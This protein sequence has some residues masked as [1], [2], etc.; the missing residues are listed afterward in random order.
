MTLHMDEG[1]MPAD[2]I[3]GYLRT[4]REGRKFKQKDFGP[5]I[6]MSERAYIDW[7]LG[8]TGDMKS[9]FLLRAL[10]LLGATWEDVQQ[11]AG[12]TYEK[13]SELAK[14]RLTPQE[15]EQVR[16]VA[17]ATAAELNDDELDELIARYEAIRSDPK[18]LAQWLGY[19]DR[20][21]A[22][23]RE[24]HVAEIRRRRSKH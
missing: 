22:E 13:G 3:R 18:L 20:L 23:Q 21:V 4:L 19:A 1:R 10:S 9:E 16:T 14:A 5:Q 2:G 8:T 17:G 15:E 7:E 24:R 12:A 11:L 6:G